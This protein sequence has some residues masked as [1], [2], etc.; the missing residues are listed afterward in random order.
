MNKHLISIKQALNKHWISIKQALNKQFYILYIMLETTTSR[1][2][3]SASLLPL[4]LCQFKGECPL[5]LTALSLFLFIF[6]CIETTVHSL[7]HIN[8]LFL[9]PC[10]YVSHFKRAYWL[11][12]WLKL[13]SN[14]NGLVMVWSIFAEAPSRVHCTVVFWIIQILGF[15]CTYWQLFLLIT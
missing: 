10:H 4:R 1:G 5:L 11:F 14:L 3:N 13:I 8:H 15:P 7:L 2:F 12:S 6:I 9:I